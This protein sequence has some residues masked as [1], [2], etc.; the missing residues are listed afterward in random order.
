MDGVQRRPHK[1]ALRVAVQRDGLTRQERGMVDRELF[2]K[3]GK[4]KKY[5]RK[6]RRSKGITVC[7]IITEHAELET[8]RIANLLRKTKKTVECKN[9]RSRR[10]ALPEDIAARLQVLQMSPA[11]R[12]RYAEAYPPGA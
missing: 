11:I 2:P 9:S 10:S 1:L 12:D 3:R 7:D 8:V 5:V 4:Q 6:V